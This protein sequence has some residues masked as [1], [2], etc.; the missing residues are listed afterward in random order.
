VAKLSPEFAGRGTKVIGLSVDSAD[1]HEAWAED[2]E[3]VQDAS[4]NYPIIADPDRVVAAS[5]G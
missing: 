2:I 3:Q 5:T 1:S 4:V